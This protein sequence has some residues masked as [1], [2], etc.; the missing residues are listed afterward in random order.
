M[1][2]IT[3][4]VRIPSCDPHCTAGNA[5]KCSLPE[6]LRAEEWICMHGAVSARDIKAEQK[7]Q[8]FFF[9][10]FFNIFCNVLLTSCPPGKGNLHYKLLS[11]IRPRHNGRLEGRRDNGVQILG[12]T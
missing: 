9:L 8:H 2:S 1:P 12:E 10:S 5:G 4:L 11:E 7:Q 6:R 3:R